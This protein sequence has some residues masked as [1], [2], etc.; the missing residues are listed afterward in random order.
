MAMMLIGSPSLP[1][2]HLALGIDAGSRILRITMHEMQMAYEAIREDSCKLNIAL[3]AALEPRLIKD[4]RTVHTNVNSVA[5]TGT[6]TL[7]FIFEI[8]P[9]NGK[10]LS[11]AKDHA[12]RAQDAVNET[13]PTIKHQT[14]ITVR[15]FV[16]TFVLGIATWNI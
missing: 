6:C 1:N 13:F 15:M 7:G 14:A 16:P 4:S 3:K 12:C 10:P 8:Q 11:R 5:L 2:D 9:E